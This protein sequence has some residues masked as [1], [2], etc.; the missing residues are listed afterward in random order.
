[1]SITEPF[2]K[3]LSITES[4]GYEIS[5]VDKMWIKQ[6]LY[7]MFCLLSAFLDQRASST[8]LRIAPVSVATHICSASGAAMSARWATTR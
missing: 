5:T 1:M 6:Q 2:P 8:S 3:L 7:W 4:V